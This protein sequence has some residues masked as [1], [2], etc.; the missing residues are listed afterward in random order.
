MKK[1]ARFYQIANLLSLDVAAGAIVSG[2]FFGRIFQVDILSWGLG[3]L[4]LT[5]WIIYTADHLYDARQLNTPASSDRHRFHQRHFKVLLFALLVTLSVDLIL[6]SLLRKPVFNAGLMLGVIVGI[7]LLIQRNLKSLKELSGAMLY[8]SGVA[9]PAL[10]I[11]HFPITT[12]QGLLLAQFGITVFC[13]L[14]LFSLFDLRADLRDRHNSFVT[15]MGEEKTRLFLT[16]LFIINSFLIVLQMFHYPKIVGA[17]VVMLVMNLILFL[18]FI[19]P[20]LFE[21]NGLYR[22]LGD[23]VF[24]VPGFFLLI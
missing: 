1:L 11:T 5:V 13:N 12:F 2:L 14:L 21:I 20:R 4:G 24:L 3:A 15:V 22:L 8:C 19:F 23:A 6:I 10:S 9:L 17:A 7:Y 18:I 16:T